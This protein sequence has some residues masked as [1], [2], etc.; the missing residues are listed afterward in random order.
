MFERRR[1]DTREIRK[2]QQIRREVRSEIGAEIA[3]ERTSPSYRNQNRDQ[4]RGDW[5]RSRRHGDEG[6][7]RDERLDGDDG[8][9]PNVGE[10]E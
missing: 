8:L 1:G 9:R 5:D 7:S 6:R 4:A 10:N 2:D 3:Q